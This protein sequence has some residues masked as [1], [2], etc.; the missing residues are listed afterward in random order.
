MN[1]VKKL[2]KEKLDYIILILFLLSVSITL[3]ILYTRNS[4]KLIF[5]TVQDNYSVITNEDN[6]LEFNVKCSRQD[7]MYLQKEMIDTTY[8][9]DY[10]TE[11]N[12]LIEVKDIVYLGRYSYEGD[13]YF[14]YRF[15]LMLPFRSDQEIELNNFYL[16][17]NYLNNETLNLKMGS[18]SVLSTDEGDRE[19]VIKNLKGI[20]NEYDN[21]QYLVGIIFNFASINNFIEI[22]NI[23]PISTII[24]NDLENIKLLESVEIN[25][26]MSISELLEYDYNPFSKNN[27]TTISLDLDKEKA[28]LVPLKYNKK[29]QIKTLGFIIEYLNNGEYQYQLV[30]PFQFFNTSIESLVEK[31]EYDYD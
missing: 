16:V 25:S 24:E 3:L 12:Y 22:I 28:I 27:K 15:Q 10:T 31:V 6:L 11:D 2:F 5:L 7:T 13:S 17:I 30:Y 21:K 4:E 23:N 8:L 19:I 9:L 14:D 1:Y 29:V 26:T 20:V 18:L